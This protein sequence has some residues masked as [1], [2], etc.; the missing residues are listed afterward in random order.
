MANVICE[1]NSTLLEINKDDFKW[2]FNKQSKKVF[3]SISF[4]NMIQNLSNLR[5]LKLSELI[6]KNQVISRMTELQKSY[7]NTLLEPSKIYTK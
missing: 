3:H 7:L 6:Y 4:M 1:T 5:K 2:V